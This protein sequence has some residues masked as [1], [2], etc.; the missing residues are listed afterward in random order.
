MNHKIKRF[1]FDMD[2]S[3][4]R[5]EVFYLDADGKI[6]DREH[7]KTYIINFYDEKG[8]RIQEMFGSFD[9]NDFFD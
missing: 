8:E 2:Y 3:N 5:Q 7:A 1:D 9:E 6:T 4:L